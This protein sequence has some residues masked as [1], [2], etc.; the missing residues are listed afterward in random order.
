[1]ALGAVL[2][3]RSKTKAGRP[4]CPGDTTIV[5]PS[6]D[7]TV[8]SCGRIKGASGLLSGYNDIS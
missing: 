7:L 1:M 8:A 2:S 3:P 5:R 4:P 6:G